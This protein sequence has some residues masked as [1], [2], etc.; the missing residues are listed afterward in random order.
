LATDI[1]FKP[2][3]VDFVV[4]NLSV[5]L[6]VLT[7]LIIALLN[8]GELTTKT[9]SR[10]FDDVLFIYSI[11]LLIQLLLFFAQCNKIIVSSNSF[12]VIYF[13]KSSLQFNY[14]SITWLQVRKGNRTE[15]LEIKDKTGK[16]CT[17]YLHWLKNSALF[18]EILQKRTN[19]PLNA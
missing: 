7:P 2:K 17:L 12:T 13:Y 15:I 5:L 9:M 8:N 1:L 6:V 3:Y 10:Y 16:G 18:L 11:I 19:V 4:L 14:D